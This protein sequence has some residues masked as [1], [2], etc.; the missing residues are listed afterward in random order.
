MV[1]F[2]SLMRKII[3]TFMFESKFDIRMFCVHMLYNIFQLLLAIKSDK[4]IINIPP[5][6]IWKKY[7]GQSENHCFSK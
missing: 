6:N 1:Y 2:D 3:I 5:I 7:C 4:N